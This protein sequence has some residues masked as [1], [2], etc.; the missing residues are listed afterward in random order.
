MKFAILGK[1]SLI[2]GVVAALASS[3][4]LRNPSHEWE[5]S[6]VGHPTECRVS[7]YYCTAQHE[8]WPQHKPN[9]QCW[10]DY[11]CLSGHC[12][13]G[14]CA[15]FPYKP[16]LINIFFKKGSTSSSLTQIL[17]FKQFLKFN[18]SQIFFV[19]SSKWKLRDFSQLNFKIDVVYN[20]DL[21]L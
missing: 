16:N 19:E 15:W 17:I 20:G 2:I 8:C 1:W 9:L 5:C 6:T 3:M 21:F 4:S 11:E 12:N 7:T 10:N 14:K 18:L 13:S